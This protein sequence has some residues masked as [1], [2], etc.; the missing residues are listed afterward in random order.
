[1]RGGERAD[2]GDLRRGEGGGGGASVG[3]GRLWAGVWV[4]RWSGV[5]PL[6]Q[7]PGAP[8]PPTVALPRAHRPLCQGATAAHPFTPRS[9]HRPL[10]RASPARSPPAHTKASH[11]LSMV[12]E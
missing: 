2:G 8:R 9:S 6:R 3:P 5:A 11:L 7:R 1:V 12:L 10:K 4:V